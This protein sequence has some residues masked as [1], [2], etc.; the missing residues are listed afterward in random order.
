MWWPS[1]WLF[2][3]LGKDHLLL[4]QAA[5][6]CS[7]WGISRTLAV[8]RVRTLVEKRVRTL[9]VKRVGTLTGMLVVLETNRRSTL[10]YRHQKIF[11]VGNK[12]KWD[13]LILEL[14]ST[15][16]GSSKACWSRRWRPW[17]GHA[18]VY[19]I[20]KRSFIPRESVLSSA[21]PRLY[22]SRLCRSLDSW[23]SLIELSE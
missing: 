19:S 4:E 10:I 8:K 23:N 20:R 2:I 5:A 9:A 12:V 3:H 15:W 21:W 18:R 14:A 17:K 7:C 6:F 16:A 22:S 13:L 11:L 1:A